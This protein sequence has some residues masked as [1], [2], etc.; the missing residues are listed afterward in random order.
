MA[1]HLSDVEGPALLLRDVIG[2]SDARASRSGCV[3]AALA[4]T[5]TWGDVYLSRWRRRA[6]SAEENRR[7]GPHEV[8]GAFL[9]PAGLTLRA[10]RVAVEWGP[11]G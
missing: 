9:A 1:W 6:G 11:R 5:P 7:T 8:S 10:R 4:R 2:V 3:I